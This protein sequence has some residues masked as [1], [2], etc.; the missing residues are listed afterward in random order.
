[1]LQAQPLFHNQRPEVNTHRDPNLRTHGI[2]AATEKSLDAQVF[3]RLSSS[4]LGWLA[5]SCRAEFVD[6]MVLDDEIVESKKA[7]R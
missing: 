3:G 5:S 6:V 1:M 4:S 2:V 7:Y